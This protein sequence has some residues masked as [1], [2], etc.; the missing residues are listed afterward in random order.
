MKRFLK[1]P[2]GR[3]VHL[4][5]GD[6]DGACTVYSLMMGLIAA[7]KVKKDD[8]LDLGKYEKVDGRKSLG[9]LL[10]EFFERKPESSDWPET[11]LLRNGYR[12]SHIQ[13]KLSR[14]YGKMVTSW[15]GSSDLNK[16]ESGYMDKKE[17]LG[18]IAEE[19]DKGCPVEIAFD[20]RNS[21]SGHAVLVVGYEMINDEPQKL[22]CLDPGFE[23]PEKKKYNAVI[24]THH[25]G[26]NVQ[27]HEQMKRVVTIKEALSLE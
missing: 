8:L 10:K 18:F 16:D 24:S 17:L 23:A 15:Y 4:R 5:Q 20:Y 25:N 27:F 26:K 2:D 1:M 22:F 3:S 12:L 14:S 9:R 11:I 7:K 19:I 21:D 6:L 13:D